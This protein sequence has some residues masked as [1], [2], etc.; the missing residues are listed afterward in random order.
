M[1]DCDVGLPRGLI[2]GVGEEYIVFRL[3]ARCFIV[4]SSLFKK[5]Y[6]LYILCRASPLTTLARYCNN[7]VSILNG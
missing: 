2:G 3:C 6:R 7:F 4:F 1:F 5:F